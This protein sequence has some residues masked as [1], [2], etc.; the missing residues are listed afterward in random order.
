M[1]L[2]AEL[3]HQVLFHTS[4]VYSYSEYGR[5]C[6]IP[7][8]KATAILAPF[9]LVS[10]E[11]GE[12]ASF[13]FFSYNH[14][15]CKLLQMPSE[16]V[17]SVLRSHRP[18]DLRLIRHVEILIETTE[19]AQWDA[20]QSDKWEELMTLVAEKFQLPNL[21]L[22][23]EGWQTYDYPQCDVEFRFVDSEDPEWLN[24]LYK[25]IVRPLAE[26][27]AF[28]KLKQLYIFWECAHELVKC[29]P[30]RIGK[31]GQE[32]D[33]TRHGALTSTDEPYS[34]R[35]GCQSRAKGRDRWGY[36]KTMTAE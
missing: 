32:F 9:A 3:R 24:D 35:L 25:K 18:E 28:Q 5:D 31:F 17:L 2:P 29:N 4:L 11:F 33:S 27:P 8:D 10:R 6:G 21:H 36:L 22:A 26:E 15:Y 12:N 13:V 14:F 16:Y 7:F 1:R 34:F 19:A 23:I 30:I 20:Q